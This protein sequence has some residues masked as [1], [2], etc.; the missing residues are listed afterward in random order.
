MG[1]SSLQREIEGL[2]TK[3]DPQAS[4]RTVGELARI[5]GDLADGSERKPT[6][7]LPNLRL[8]FACKER[9]ENMVGDDR[10]RACS[11][12]DR[13]G[14]NLSAM[15]RAEA[16]RL[17]ATR[18]LTPCVRFYRRPDGTVMTTDCPTGSRRE[19]RRL[20]VVASSLAA[21]TALAAPASASAAPDPVTS[22]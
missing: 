9:W 2:E 3:L 5:R 18:G 1:T 7:D 19:S 4:A 16:E 20:A 11:G 10:V 15:T 6:I 12:C 22:P 13:P 17:L 21:G 14:F 8:G